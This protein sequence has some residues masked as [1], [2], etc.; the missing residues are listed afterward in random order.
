MKTIHNDYREAR[1][2]RKEAERKYQV[3]GHRYQVAR[4][5]YE[6]AEREC[7]EIF[8]KWLK[9]KVKSNDF[10]KEWVKGKK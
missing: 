1:R 9:E 6:E 7:R 10:R 5:R 2:K 3:A 4:H 8:W